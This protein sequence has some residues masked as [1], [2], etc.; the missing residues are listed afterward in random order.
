MRQNIGLNGL[1]RAIRNKAFALKY[2]RQVDLSVNVGRRML[3]RT[4]WAHEMDAPSRVALQEILLLSQQ[5]IICCGA[6]VF[7]LSPKER[8]HRICQLKNSLQN[9]S[10]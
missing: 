5:M 3:V 6:G 10:R 9:L 7:I 4:E 8:R 2:V 1:L